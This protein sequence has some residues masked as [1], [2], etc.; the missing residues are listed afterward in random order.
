MYTF[1]LKAYLVPMKEQKWAYS[2]E[3]MEQ[4][5]MK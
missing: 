2:N 1:K 4:I 5:Y 3:G